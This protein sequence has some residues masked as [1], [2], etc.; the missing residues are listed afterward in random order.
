MAPRKHGQPLQDSQLFPNRHHHCVS[1]STWCYLDL[2]PWQSIILPA[3]LY[4]PVQFEAFPAPVRSCQ[5]A[6]PKSA[7]L[8]RHRYIIIENL[9]INDT[10]SCAPQQRDLTIALM[11]I[12]AFLH[13]LCCFTDSYM[14]SQ[15]TR[16]II[17]MVPFYG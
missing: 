1:I 8:F 12:F 15:S 9:V 14:T 10:S 16:V 6:L 13:T 5:G 2:A 17:F 3:V 11:V 4:V 7:Y